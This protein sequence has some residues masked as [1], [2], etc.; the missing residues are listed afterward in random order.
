MPDD[1]FKWIFKDPNWDFNTLDVGKHLELARKADGGNITAASADISKFINRGGKMI[2]YHG[3][4]DPNISPRS[5]TNYYERLLSTLGPQIV[6]NSVRLYMVPGMGHCGGGDGP[7]QFDMLTQ[8]EN[9]REK[10]QAP[11]QVIASRIENGKTV[12]TRPL[13]PYPQIDRYTG[14]GSIDDAKNFVCMAP[15]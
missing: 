12:R 14:A 1:F 13:C 11:T 15:Q 8:L 5:S 4:E 7:N 9:W 3:W 6:E 2:I 10:G